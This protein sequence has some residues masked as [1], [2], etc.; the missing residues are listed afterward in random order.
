MPAAIFLVHRAATHLPTAFCL[1]E[2][3]AWSYHLV[4]RCSGV[5]WVFCG[6]GSSGGPHHQLTSLPP[7]VPRLECA[8][9]AAPSAL[10]LAARGLSHISVLTLSGVAATG[11]S[12][13]SW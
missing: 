3:L 4:P 10:A 12:S 8:A 11:A 5:L 6:C 2:V 13:N 1:Q 7:R 9:Q